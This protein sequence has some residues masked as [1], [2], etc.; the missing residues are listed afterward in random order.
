MTTH[1]LDFLHLWSGY[2][3]EYRLASAV[4]SALHGED[5]EKRKA[6]LATFLGY[7][8][9]NALNL[10]LNH[11]AIVPLRHLAKIATFLGIDLAVLTTFWLATYAA[12]DDESGVIAKSI[13]PRITDAEFDLIETARAVYRDEADD[14]SE[15]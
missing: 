11:T 3:A 10:W 1:D 14:R 15:P 9:P 5:Y 8:K 12:D 7:P 4:D 6:A 13:E 2:P